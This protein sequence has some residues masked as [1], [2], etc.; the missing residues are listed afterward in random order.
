[1]TPEETQKIITEALESMGCTEIK[2]QKQEPE[3]IDVIFNCKEFT[4]FVKGIPGWTYSGI[5]LDTSGERQYKI[6]F[7]KA[8]V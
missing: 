5:Q 1:M 6:T 7:R 2:F 8:S 4:S 3:A